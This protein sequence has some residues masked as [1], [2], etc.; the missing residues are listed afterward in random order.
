MERTFPVLRKSF[1]F[2]VNTG[3]PS[4][5]HNG[6]L[7]AFIEEVPRTRIDDAAPGCPEED[8]ID[9]P[10]ILPPSALSI[11]TTGAFEILVPLTELT[12]PVFASLVT[13]P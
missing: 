4:I 1:G 11:E 2:P 13:V 10:A 7:P 3:I 12:E 8:V 9:T 6:L 5:T